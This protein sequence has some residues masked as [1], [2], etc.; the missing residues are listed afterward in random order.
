MDTLQHSI[1]SY[2]WI[3]RAFFS[4]KLLF[5]VLDKGVIMAYRRKHVASSILSRALL[6]TVCDKKNMLIQRG[7]GGICHLKRKLIPP[8]PSQGNIKD[9]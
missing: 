8:P 3:Y 7:E 5:N 4:N 1:T 2:R 9:P 6:V